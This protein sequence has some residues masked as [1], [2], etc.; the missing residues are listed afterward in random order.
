LLLFFS[1]AERVEDDDATD[2][3]T[4]DGAEGKDEGQGR[5]KVKAIRKNGDHSERQPKHVEPDW[6]V[7]LV[8]E[9]FAETE[10]Q[11]KR[12][13]ADG[14]DNHERERARKRRLAG[15]DDNQRQ[16]DQEQ[17][18]G[19]EAPASG[20]GCGWRIGSGVRQAI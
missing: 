4:E 6:S 3:E 1:L 2:G 14:G 7:N 9:P 8:G 16:S 20:L 15:V 10:L 11:K 13:Q 12:G 18:R 5:G 17:S 19:N